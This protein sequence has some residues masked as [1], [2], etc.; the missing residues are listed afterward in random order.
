MRKLLSF[1]K[2]N[3]GVIRPTFTV[4]VKSIIEP[5]KAYNIEELDK[6]FNKEGSLNTRFMLIDEF[7]S[8]L[9][10]K[11]ELDGVPDRPI[12][13][14][15]RFGV[16]LATI[17]AI[18]V[19]VTKN[20]V[21]FNKQE[22]DLV[23]EILRHESVHREQSEKSKGTALAYSLERGPKDPKAYFSHYTELMAYARSYVDQCKANGQSK[24]DILK[25][26]R[27]GLFG[28]RSW[29]PD[30]FTRSKVGE[31]EMKRFKKYVYQYLEDDEKE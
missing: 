3:E 17:D 5:N 26:L 20:I 30:A 1:E 29:I 27:A 18:V 8:H 10:T 14:N 19:C 25:S 11:K 23:E 28:S 21:N 4:D 2:F 6:L 31:D 24:D 22:I 9:T 13:P 16:Y 7:K 12:T 15:L